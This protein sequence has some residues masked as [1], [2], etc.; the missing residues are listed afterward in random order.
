M[1]LSRDLHSLLVR[2]LLSLSF[3]A[4]VS[5]DWGDMMEITV[6]NNLAHNG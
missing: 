5:V 2:A 6:I 3:G 4:N 1:G